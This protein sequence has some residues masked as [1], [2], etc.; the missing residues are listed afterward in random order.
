ME[1]KTGLSFG[2]SGR[3]CVISRLFAS[4]HSSVFSDSKC[5][6]YAA[7]QRAGGWW[8]MVEGISDLCIT[9]IILPMF[10]SVF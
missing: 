10:D 5:F 2:K 1:K 8:G 3:F 6:S 9:P 4:L 7:L